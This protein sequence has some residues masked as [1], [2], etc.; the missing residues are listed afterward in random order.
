MSEEA[1]GSHRPHETDGHMVMLPPPAEPEAQIPGLVTNARIIGAISLA[2]TNMAKPRPAY[3]KFITRKYGSL[4]VSQPYGPFYF[5][6]NY[7][8]IFQPS[9]KNKMID[10]KF[11][12]V[13]MM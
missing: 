9:S 8:I 6:N 5:L 10:M 12:Y 3:R 7:F 13:E 11:E 1:I 2:G 4:D